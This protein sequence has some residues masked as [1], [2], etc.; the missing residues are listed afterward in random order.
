MV[1]FCTLFDCYY[2]DK[3]LALYHSLKKVMGDFCLY[4]FAMDRSA[5][6]I[7]CDLELENSVIVSEDEIL[8]QELFEIKMTRK[9]AEYC[10]T[11]T[12]II[13]EYVLEHFKVSACTYI[14][15]DLYFYKDPNILI[16]ELKKNF[17]SVGI[18]G[19]RF[20]SKILN[21]KREKLYGK[22]CVEFNTFF[23]DKYGIKVLEWWK[24][25]CLECCTMDLYQEGYGDQKYLEQ[26]EQKFSGV[27]EV[28]NVGA[29]VAPWN[30]TDYRLI[31][32]RGASTWV[33]Y[34]NQME[35]EL[36]FYHFQGLRMLNDREAHIAVYNEI[37]NMDN[38]LIQ[39]I[40]NDYVQEISYIRQYLKENYQ[41][42]FPINEIR[43]GERGNRKYTGLIDE[44]LYLYQCL[45]ILVRGKKNYIRV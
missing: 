17:A 18:M 36:I 29:G 26:W 42:V 10:W 39:L 21:S 32:K 37:G 30:I 11:C 7:L 4:I 22:Y 35:C 24:K 15:A 5:Y 1:S 25:K 28:Q 38:R 33:K 6:D 31:G 8:N 43:P 45:I 27:Y 3:G 16:D 34:K 9:R 12:P 44:I 20:P 23:N 41:F 40:Y 13:V 2:M 19:H 14:D